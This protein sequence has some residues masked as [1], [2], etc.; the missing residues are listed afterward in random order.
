[1]F[2]RADHV[3]R[4]FAMS[5]FAAHAALFASYLAPAIAAAFRRHAAPV[6]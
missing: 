5:D 1:M 3:P 6:G 4:L 2:I